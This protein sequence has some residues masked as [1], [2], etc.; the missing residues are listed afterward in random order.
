MVP[1]R[2]KRNYCTSLFFLNPRLGLDDHAADGDCFLFA[3]VLKLQIFLNHFCKTA[4]LLQNTGKQL[5]CTY[6]LHSLHLKHT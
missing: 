4:T 5:D 3:P 1:N 2:G 6:T